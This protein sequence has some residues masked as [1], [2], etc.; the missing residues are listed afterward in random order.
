MEVSLKINN[1][2][3]TNIQQFCEL[4]KIE[5]NEYILTLVE[6]GFNIDKYGDLNDTL[7]ITQKIDKKI[8]TETNIN[9]NSTAIYSDIIQIVENEKEEKPIEGI[10]IH[11]SSS[12]EVTKVLKVNKKSRKLNSK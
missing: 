12:D 8:E 7:N 10:L 2:L 5:I 1:R 6:R 3:Y 11:K 9:P 4:N